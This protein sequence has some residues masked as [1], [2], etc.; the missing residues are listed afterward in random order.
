MLR[1]GEKNKMK[2]VTMS[3]ILLRKDEFTLHQTQ[4]KPRF[5]ARLYSLEKLA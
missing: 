5:T 3:T 4:I 2:D 1:N